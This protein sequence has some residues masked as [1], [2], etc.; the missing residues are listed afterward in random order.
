MYGLS[1]A[2]NFFA[3]SNI[4]LAADDREIN[5]L[6]SETCDLRH[7]MKSLCDELIRPEIKALAKPREHPVHLYIHEKN[8]ECL[9]RDLL[10]LTIMCETG[11]SKRDRMELFLDIYGNCLLRDKSDVYLQTVVQ[12]LIQLVTEDERCPSVLDEMVD[13]S[14]LKFA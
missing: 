9:A 6:I 3:D 10:F 1:S 2:I 8:Y 13:F 5:V 12:E 7:I 4:D 14:T 11:M